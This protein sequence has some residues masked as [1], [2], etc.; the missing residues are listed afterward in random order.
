MALHPEQKRHFP[1]ELP[2]AWDPIRRALEEDE[3]WYR[4]LVEHSQD[5]LCVHDLEGRFLSVNPVPARLLGYSVEEM[6]RKPMR[7][8]VDPEFHT[9]FDA[10]LREIVR[11][12]E[13]RGRLAVVTRFGEQRIWDYHNTLR[14]ETGAAPI[15]RGMA[16]DVTD[17]VRAE[18]ALRASNEQL[19]KA[20]EDRDRTIRDLTLF[21]TLLDQS[22]DA[23]KVIDPETLRFLD[24]N[25]KSYAELGYSREE[26]L[27]L[28]V[29][30]IDPSTDEG[31]VARARQQLQ[32]FGFSIMET[33]HRRKDGKTFPV[34]VNMRRVR[35]DREYTVS[36]SRN[37]TERKAVEERLRE[38]ERVV[39]SLEEMIVVMNR[40]YRYIIANRAFL[41]YRGLTK[42]QV[43]GRLAAEILDPGVFEAAIKEKLDESFQGKIVNFE[44]RYRYPKLGERDLF[45]TYLPVETVA[46]IDRVACV[47]R[48][49]TERKQAEVAL[50]ESEARERTRAKE[51]ETVLDAVPVAV[52]IAHDVECRRMT[53]N[54]AAHE[55]MRVPAGANFSRSAPPEE[56]PTFR[57]MQDGVEI[58]KD[59]LPMQQAATGEPVH[60]R[61][62][63]MV[64]EDGVERETVVTAV[65]LLDEEGKPRGVV[66]AS[67]DVTERKQVERALRQSE[68]RFRT[69]YER[70]PIGIA[71]VDSRTGR[72]MQVNP[73]FCEIVGRKEEDLLRTDVASITHP[74]DIIETGEVLQQLAEEK[75]ATCEVEKRY[76]R[77]DG[78]ARW[79]RILAVPIWN[80]GDQQRW[81]MSLVE[82]V[83]ERKLVKQ[84]LEEAHTELAHVTRVLAL[85]EMVTSIAH[86]VNQP[87]SGIVMNSEFALRQL[88]SKMPNLRAVEDAIAEVVEDA[89]RVSTFIARVRGLVKKG[90]RGA[91]VLNINEVVQDVV[92]LL[93]NEAA[94]SGVQVQLDLGADLPRVLA[95]RVQLQQVLINLVLNGIDAMRAAN[96][97]RRLDIKSERHPDGV[98]VVVRDSGVGLN[99]D[100]VDRIFDP[101]FTTKPDGIGMGLSISRSIIESHG[102]RLWTEPCSHGAIFQF[103]LPTNDDSGS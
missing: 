29:R 86:E 77:P 10:Y 1:E 64:F 76:L 88:S 100:R 69:V 75:R 95:D 99:P 71:L 36:I 3:D 33:I 24:V 34:E 22:N 90:D 7:E 72:F 9:Q 21:R 40:E 13:S 81:H 83:T 93:R 78:S 15:V 23:I 65:P 82:D 2:V 46:G 19:L 52:L 32:E 16:H 62:L 55:Q 102:G 74:D 25:E 57:L 18:M 50:R 45:I 20:A 63:T 53:G 35:L 89:T 48:D 8:F 103:I 12:G 96:P 94:L 27:S 14:T 37:I 70:S 61:A 87:L 73:K 42:E 5:L 56:P 79:V 31:V 17:R 11:T 4:D 97:P 60:R 58:P 39:E 54:R 67:I 66:G 38:F 85:G 26:L 84:S 6:M 98:L 28:T 68:M 41:T 43:I 47:I 80:K 44:F 59:M 91:I 92:L 49:V 51:L 101:F 30:D